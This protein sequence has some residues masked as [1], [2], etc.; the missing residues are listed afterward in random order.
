VDFLHRLVTH[1]VNILLLTELIR[2]KTA[3]SVMNAGEVVA[4][5]A[6]SCKG[7][8]TGRKDVRAALAKQKDV[9]LKEYSSIQFRYLSP[10]ANLAMLTACGAGH[11]HCQVRI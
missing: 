8:A 9:A 7:A 11:R 5:K 6:A 10:V 1:R 2:R 3:V 4:A